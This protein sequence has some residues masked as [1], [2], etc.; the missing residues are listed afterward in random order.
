MKV[1]ELITE[2]QKYDPNLEALCLAEGEYWYDTHTLIDP[3]PHYSSGRNLPN[4]LELDCSLDKED[5]ENEIIDH[6]RQNG[7][8]N[9]GIL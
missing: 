7:Y 6:I 1:H 4:D 5:K 9:L 2:L 3:S 8:I